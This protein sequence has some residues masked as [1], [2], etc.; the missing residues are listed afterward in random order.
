MA[1][2]QVRSR[3]HDS[4]FASLPFS[5]QLATFSPPSCASKKCSN[6]SIMPSLFPQVP[7]SYQTP[8]TSPNSNCDDPTRILPVPTG[9]ANSHWRVDGV[10]RCRFNRGV[11]VA[12][13]TPGSAKTRLGEGQVRNP[14]WETIC[15]IRNIS[16]CPRE[17]LLEAMMRGKVPDSDQA[18]K[19]SSIKV[20]SSRK[21]APT[22]GT[23]LEAR[24]RGIKV[25]NISIDTTPSRRLFPSSHGP[26][27]LFG[28]SSQK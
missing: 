19:H 24:A 26:L 21:R 18:L 14:R 9:A 15:P 23:T 11:W 3:R 2:T 8:T 10:L 5:C 1:G 7:P 20:L 4:L 6:N 28:S 13:L 22:A 25:I 27:S 16:P 12:S 17:C